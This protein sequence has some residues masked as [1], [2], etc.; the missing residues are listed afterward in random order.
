MIRIPGPS[1]VSRARATSAVTAEVVGGGLGGEEQVAD[2]HDPPTEGDLDP[3]DAGFGREG[4]S[5]GARFS[6]VGA[7][8]LRRLCV[9]SHGPSIVEASRR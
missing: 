2:H 5:L 8:L 4:A 3:G 1:Q 7:H 9:R 6:T